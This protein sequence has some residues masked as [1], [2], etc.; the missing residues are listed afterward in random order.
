MIS[1]EE[2]RNLI[3]NDDNI[4]QY[5]TQFFRNRTDRNR[6]LVIGA[7]NEALLDMGVSME[8]ITRTTK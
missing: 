4:Q 3:S 6:N 7:I 1:L 8:T 2:L 5:V